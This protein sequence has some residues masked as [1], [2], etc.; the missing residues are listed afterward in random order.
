MPYI[1][2][3]DRESL[4]P[5]IERSA[6]TPGELNFQLT[7]VALDF[8]AFNGKSYATANDIIGAF[9]AAK[10]EFYRRVVAPY[11]D[12]KIAVNGDVYPDA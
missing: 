2:E 9:E 3:A 6:T 12:R 8:L 4:T 10:L 7:Q 1:D 5:A 11:E